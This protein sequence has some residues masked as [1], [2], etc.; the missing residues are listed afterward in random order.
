MSKEYRYDQA[1][2]RQQREGM[3]VGRLCKVTAFDEKKGTVDVQPLEKRLVNGRYEQR[4]PILSVPISNTGG[5]KFSFSRQYSAGDTVMIAY[6]DSD[7]DIGM[8]KGSDF[9]PNTPRSHQGTD[10]V[11]LGQVNAGG[12]PA[13]T[14][15]GGSFGMGTK[16]G[17]AYAVVF[18]DGRVVIKSPVSVEIEAPEIKLTGDVEII[19]NLKVSGNLD[20]AGAISPWP[21]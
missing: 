8:R 11:M 6:T 4:P 12:G 18:P 21:V 1:R 20:V 5:G 10:A 9:D 19:G 2:E 16:D 15:P 7:I 13:S 17:D 14:L 3:N